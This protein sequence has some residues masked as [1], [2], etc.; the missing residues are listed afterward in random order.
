MTNGYFAN[1]YGFVPLSVK[2]RVKGPTREATSPEFATSPQLLDLSNW[3]A[4]EFQARLVVHFT[5]VSPLLNL[6]VVRERDKENERQP[7][8]FKVRRDGDGQP[9]V[10]GSALRGLV[11]SVYEQISGSS[12]GVFS[13]KHEEKLSY[14]QWNKQT[15]SL[16]A[17]DFDKSPW[18]LTP[19][20]FRPATDK[21]SS[22]DVVFGW[23]PG[24]DK[25][26]RGVRSRVRFG[27]VR[28]IREDL[29]TPTIIEG[30]PWGLAI[31]S[32]P[33]PQSGR[34]YLVDTQ[35]GE[36][37][38]G[39][40][41][42]L[43]YSKG[44]RIAGHKV[45]PHHRVPDGYWEFPDHWNSADSGANHPQVG[46]HYQN[47]LAPT[48]VISGS[49]DQ[50]ITISEYVPIG[51]SFETTVFIEGLT[52][53][54]LAM[55]LWAITLGDVTG[56]EERYHRLGRGRPLGF[57][58]IK[59]KVDWTKSQIWTADQWLARYCGAV[60]SAETQVK[61]I[62]KK[63]VDQATTALKEDSAVYNAIIRA[64]EG[65]ELPIHYPRLGSSAQ[66][67][68][69]SQTSYEWF[70]ANDRGRRLGL[71]RL[72]AGSQALPNQPGNGAGNNRGQG[73]R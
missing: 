31:L 41:K 10:T 27:G 46:G 48:A 29:A 35:T 8:E 39:T 47:F 34:F 2:L 71:P 26:E 63:M 37:L 14:K 66:E 43:F 18:E 64:A 62:A 6:E 38:D 67:A 32:S 73:R 40:A 1:P 23:V 16:D 45:Y 44:Q 19:T 53:L 36:P 42:P 52:Y 68:A 49:A 56:E 60:V 9:V 70:N 50:S 3:S 5:T 59:M 33:K 61:E 57:G 58:S 51:V 7:A 21:L 4:S 69:P 22:A 65:I 12:F 54:E 15:R 30:G 25:D 17:C 13:S 11:R 20:L 24:S 55:L 28:C 72:G